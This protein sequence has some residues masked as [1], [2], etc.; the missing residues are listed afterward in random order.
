MY[1]K[2]YADI[3]FIRIGQEFCLLTNY[4]LND[5]FEQRYPDD[6]SDNGETEEE[7]KRR[8]EHDA[9]YRVH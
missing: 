3:K 6:N 7:N 1:Y 9:V 8:I 5:P 2:T 4:F